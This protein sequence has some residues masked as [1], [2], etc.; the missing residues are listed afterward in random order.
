MGS[1]CMKLNDDRC[2]EKDILQHKPFS[3]I[4]AK[5]LWPFD[6]K[7]HRAYPRLMSLCM[8]YKKRLLLS[9]IHHFKSDLINNMDHMRISGTE[10]SSV[11]LSQT[12][13]INKMKSNDPK[14]PKTSWSQKGWCN[15]PIKLQFQS[16]L[17]TDNFDTLQTL[18]INRSRP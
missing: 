16:I 2:K 5:W 10:P 12:C 15:E 4:T 11:I 1:L 14:A 3:V 9:W 8:K 17:N 13:S 7:I 18:R 6:P